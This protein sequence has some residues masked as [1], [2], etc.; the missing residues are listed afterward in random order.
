MGVLD[1]STH[2]NHALKWGPSTSNPNPP[3]SLHP[4]HSSPKAME[5][6]VAPR[7]T[8]ERCHISTEMPMS[9]CLECQRGPCTKMAPSVIGDHHQPAETVT[10][11]PVTAALD[12]DIV[13]SALK[14]AIHR[15]QAR[16]NPCP[17][18]G[19]KPL[20]VKR[21]HLALRQKAISTLIQTTAQQP[22]GHGRT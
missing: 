4:E 14:F 1:A 15:Y 18:T 20:Q 9:P 8:S 6:L 21:P 17:N 16:R 7:T 11:Q 2:A 22:P 19:D 3:L 13:G 5:R 10:R 12:R